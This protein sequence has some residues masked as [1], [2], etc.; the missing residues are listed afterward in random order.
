MSIFNIEEKINNLL[1]SFANALRTKSVQ[2]MSS[3]ADKKPED[4]PKHDLARAMVLSD[5]AEILLKM[6]A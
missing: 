4:I 3:H 2:I 6:K 1:K 5:I